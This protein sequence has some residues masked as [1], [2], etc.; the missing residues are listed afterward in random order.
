MWWKYL[1]FPNKIQYLYGKQVVTVNLFF[2]GE[3]NSLAYTVPPQKILL[4]IE[5][6]L[7]MQ[8]GQKYVIFDAT[9][10]GHVTCH[11]IVTNPFREI[12]EAL[13][14]NLTKPTYHCA[15]VLYTWQDVF[16]LVKDP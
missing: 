15:A 16:Q 10:S 11:N 14:V 4:T 13:P 8:Q 5:D 6:L 7:N 1:N 3:V 2:F 9:H 12:W